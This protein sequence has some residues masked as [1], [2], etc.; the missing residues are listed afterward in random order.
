MAG[1]GAKSEEVNKREG[2]ER[3][4]AS[5]AQGSAQPA[6]WEAWGNF[7]PAHHLPEENRRRL[8]THPIKPKGEP[9]PNPTNFDIS[10]R[11]KFGADGQLLEPG[12]RAQP[13]RG[14]EDTY[15]DIIDFIVRATHRIWEEKDVGYIYDHY[16]HNIRVVDDYGLKLG[17]DP[18]IESTLGFIN[19]F[20]DIRII[21]DEIVWAG[22]DE[23]GFHTSHRAFVTGTNT[24]HSA[25]GP[26]RAFLARRQLRVRG[27][28]ER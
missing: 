27:E 22:N 1:K 13:M 24:G 11:A 8:R 25:Y 7:P 15:T 28:R 12:P 16:R 14:F 4:E 17:R 21:A 2:E 10:L 20:P 23:V 9:R 3:L 5:G 19:A 26:P 6:R 18:V